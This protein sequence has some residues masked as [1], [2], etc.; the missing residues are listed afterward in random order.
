MCNAR[1]TLIRPRPVRAF[2]VGEEQANGR[3][4]ARMSL[5]SIENIVLVRNV[6]INE[7]SR[8]TP[9]TEKDARQK[10]RETPSQID[11]AASE[12]LC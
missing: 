1:L 5:E 10:Q 8:T 4:A 11:G 3:E 12:T 6:N 9:F 2:V 7:T